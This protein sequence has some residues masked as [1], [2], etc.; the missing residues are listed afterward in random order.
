MKILLASAKLDDIRWATGNGLLDGVLTTPSL[1]AAAGDG[2]SRE[3]LGEICRESRTPV[4]ASV[5]AVSGADIFKD[6]RELAKI[7]DQI[8]VQVPFLEDAISAMRRLSSEGVRVLATLVFTPAQALLAAKAGA[9]T[10]GV[11]VDAIDALGIEG[12]DTVAE[13]K[14][15]FA[16]TAVPCDILATNAQGASHVTACGLAGADAVA[17]S[18][19]VLR[20]LLVHPLTDRGLDHFLREL[21]SSR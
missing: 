14:S 19:E 4:Y 3:L 15:I 18:A 21:S 17:M 1:L 13:I 20:S 2:E 8:V 11:A 6:G 7:S 9:T 5:R 16:A 12:A 10:V